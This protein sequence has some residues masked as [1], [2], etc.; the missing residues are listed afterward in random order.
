LQQHDGDVSFAGFHLCQ[1]PFGNVRLARNHF[2]GHASAIA[3]L[4][5]TLAEKGQELFI[6]RRAGTGNRRNFGLRARGAFL[7]RR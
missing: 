3:Q 4:A 7:K 1:V 6:G 5:H 2:A